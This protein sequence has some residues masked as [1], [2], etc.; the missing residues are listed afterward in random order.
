MRDGAAGH[1]FVEERHALSREQE[2]RRSLRGASAPP[3]YSR[4]AAR[5][6]MGLQREGA[7]KWSV[8]VAQKVWAG[9][10]PLWPLS[11]QCAALQKGRGVSAAHSLCTALLRHKDRRAIRGHRFQRGRPS[12]KSDAFPSLA[13]PNACPQRLTVRTLERVHVGTHELQ[14]CS[15]ATAPTVWQ[16][17]RYRS[18]PSTKGEPRDGKAKSRKPESRSF[19]C[20]YCVKKRDTKVKFLG[21]TPGRA[22]EDTKKNKKG[23]TK[24]KDWSGCMV[25]SSGGWHSFRMTQHAAKSLTMLSA[26]PNRVQDIAVL[27]LFN[28][29]IDY[30]HAA[31]I[32][33]PHHSLPKI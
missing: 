25:V 18:I 12:A 10:L 26:M 13:I 4:R 3:R 30:K 29:K 17:G 8:D 6:A 22:W 32:H 2:A 21:D 16:A 24:R 23:K 33:V 5:G 9:A 28:G 15:C 31:P 7:P 11:S 14:P 1:L 20:K 27:G 19:P